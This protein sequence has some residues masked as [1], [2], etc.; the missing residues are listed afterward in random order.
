MT[1]SEGRLDSGA[2]LCFAL[3][4]N[5]NSEAALISYPNQ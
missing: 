2:A 3:R 4:W 5:S 1:I